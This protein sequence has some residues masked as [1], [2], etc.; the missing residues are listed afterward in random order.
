MVGSG[1]GRSWRAVTLGAQKVLEIDTSN[2]GPVWAEVRDYLVA[3]QIGDSA[4]PRAWYLSASSQVVSPSPSGVFFQ[5]QWIAV[6][7]TGQTAPESI[8]LWGSASD[9]YYPGSPPDRVGP[10]V[11][12]GAEL[13]IHLRV[14]Q[15]FSSVP[16]GVYRIQTSAWLAPHIPPSETEVIL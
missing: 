9:P 8:A 5:L 6:E 16:P 15:I 13:R 1:I 12:H 3:P 11:L 14:L 7:G 2:P 4:I 10:S